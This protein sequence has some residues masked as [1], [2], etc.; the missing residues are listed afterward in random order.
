MNRPQTKF[1][2]VFL[3]YIAIFVVFG[4]AA[5]LSASGPLGYDKFHDSYFFI[6]RQILLGLLPGL[7]VGYFFLNINLVK[8]RKISWLVYGGSVLLLALVFVPGVG[9]TING[10]RSWISV[11]GFNFQPSEV[12]KFALIFFAAYLLT[13]KKRN[14]HDWQMGLLPVLTLLSPA[15]L[16][17]LVQP[18][19]GTL[20]IMLVILFFMLF[21]AKVPKKYLF[22]LGI[23]A[24]A[25]FIFLIF[26][27]PYRL[28]RLTVFMHPE[29]DPKGIGYQVN[30]AFLAIGSGG[31]WG[32]GVG[33]SVQKYQYLPEVNSDSIFAVV[34]EET[35][36]LFSSAVVV[37]VVLVALRGFKIA[38]EADSEFGRLLTVGLVV[39]LAWQSF[40]NIGAT[41]GVLPLTGV[42]LPFVS[43]GGSALMSELAAVGL[44]LNISKKEV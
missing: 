40:L 15:V 21:E 5:L 17:V 19:V 41:V 24:M 36:F 16:L 23:M 18:D 42:P 25:V 39:W 12:S 33:Q 28:Q 34:A 32:R 13:D 14:L 10:A 44:I 3:A 31:F 6:K 1:D 2:K 8:W 27:K 9:A 7:I 35:G 30:Q 26:L 11:A 37:L 20:S 4:L 29:L 43:Q 22:A 38:K